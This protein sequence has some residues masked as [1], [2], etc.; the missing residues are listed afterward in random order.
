MQR[1]LETRYS[2]QLA[3]QTNPLFR[4]TRYS[5]QLASQNIWKW[6]RQFTFMIIYKYDSNEYMICTLYTQLAQK[7]CQHIAF[8]ILSS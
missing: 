1:V 5:D 8:E 4:L 2:D 7:S 6:L 3:I